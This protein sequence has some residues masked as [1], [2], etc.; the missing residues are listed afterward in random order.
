MLD[1]K[2][3][4][5]SVEAPAVAAAS[6]LKHM[7]PS[8]SFVLNMLLWNQFY[9]ASF[10]SLLSNCCSSSSVVK[11][12]PP[13][14]SGFPHSSSSSFSPSS[15]PSYWDGPPSTFAVALK[16]WAGVMMISIITRRWIS[17]RRWTPSSW[18]LIG[19]P[20]RARSWLWSSSRLCRIPRATGTKGLGRRSRG[21]WILTDRW[22]DFA[23]NVLRFWAIFKSGTFGIHSP[24]FVLRH[25]IWSTQTQPIKPWP[26]VKC[27][28][29]L[30]MSHLIDQQQPFR[31]FDRVQSSACAWSS[32]PMPLSFLST[33]DRSKYPTDLFTILKLQ[34]Q[35]HD[36]PEHRKFADL[37]ILRPQ[38]CERIVR[39][40]VHWQPHVKQRDLGNVANWS[41][42]HSS[43]GHNRVISR[44][45]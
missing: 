41:S 1:H 44:G 29:K 39:V 3:E 20:R 12:L 15:A 11:C 5:K 4:K 13:S 43:I 42:S 9:A 45:I 25:Y 18:C 24:R 26:S 23:N 27:V 37:L 31:C 34:N 8:F 19:S 17:W 32:V 22:V 14:V 36:V 16:A 40:R 33:A 10:S 21:S 38:N 7:S 2:L 35:S 28:V 6:W 30:A